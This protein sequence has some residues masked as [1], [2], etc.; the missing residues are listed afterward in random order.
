MDI[1]YL[2]S[3][4]VINS[5]IDGMSLENCDFSFIFGLRPEFILKQVHI[6]I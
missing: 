3:F 1:W 2:V 5:G 6:C 4:S